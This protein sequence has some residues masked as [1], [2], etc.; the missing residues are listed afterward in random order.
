MPPPAKS[1]NLLPLVG[2]LL[3]G[4]GVAFLFLRDSPSPRADQKEPAPAPAT[5]PARAAFQ[6][7]KPIDTS[8]FQFI[9]ANVKWDERASLAAVA[10]A[11][12]RPGRDLLD[13]FDR[14]KGLPSPDTQ[15]RMNFLLL[16]TTTHIYEGQPD[17]AYEVAS[18]ARRVAESASGVTAEWRYTFVY[19]QGVTALRRGENENCIMCRGESSCILPIAPAAVHTKPDGSRLAIRHFTEYLQQFP[20]DLGVQWLLNLAHMTLGEYPHEVEPRF[21]VTIDT[22]LNSEFDIGRF[23]DVGDRVGVNRLNQA[24]GAIMDDFDS[25]GRLDLVVTTMDPTKPMAFYRNKGDGTFEDRTEAAGLVGQLGGLN[26]VQA[27][28]NND[29]RLDIFVCRGAW[30]KTPIR[31]SLLR[32]NGNGTFTDVTEAAG[33]AAPVNSITAQWADY[34][35]DGHLDL[36]V[37]CESGPNRLYRNKGNGTFEEVAARAGRGRHR[38]AVC[39][40]AAWLDYDNDGYPDLFLNYLDGSARLFRNN[41]NGTFT[42]VTAAMGI[43]GPESGFS[44]WAWDYDNDGW[45][46]IFATCYDRTAADVVQ[47]AAGPAARA[48]HQPAVPQPGRQ[49]V[50]GRDEGGRARQRVRHDGEQLRRLRQRR[51]PRLLPGHRR[52]EPRHAGPQPDV[53]ERRR[54]SGSPRS[55]P[56]PA[57]GTCR[58]GTAWPAAT[59]T[60]TAPPTSSSRWAGRSTATSTTT[61]CSRTPARGTTG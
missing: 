15:A 59:G 40:G 11:W 44:C 22:Y 26:C 6:P 48:A 12:E 20:D 37:C 27:D 55:P 23:R 30:L 17:R 43:D 25:D 39:K 50:P 57:P 29:G 38:A 5:D 46:D 36:F 52:P 2:L 42:D 13:E 54:A 61:S 21:L 33:L 47:R 51:L 9:I 53:Q 4:G 3:L 7:R 8:G 28:Y 1:A 56:R 49:A 35:N 32:N 41:R 18:E 45:P 16:N 60:A 31:P 19:L 34:D 24:G 10:R 58:R 14:R